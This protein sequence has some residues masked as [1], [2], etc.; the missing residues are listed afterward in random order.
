MWNSM[1]PRGTEPS[2][3]QELKIVQPEN[4]SPDQELFC[5]YNN[6]AGPSPMAHKGVQFLTPLK[7]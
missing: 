4:L 5:L 1:D 7:T 2:L 6:L 3:S